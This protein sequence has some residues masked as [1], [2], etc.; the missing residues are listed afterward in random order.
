MRLRGPE[1]CLC[2]F[3]SATFD[4]T[5]GTSSIAASTDAVLGRASRNDGPVIDLIPVEL[6]LAPDLHALGEFEPP[7]FRFAMAARSSSRPVAGLGFSTSVLTTCC[8]RDMHSATGRAR[9]N[10]GN[11]IWGP[12]VFGRGEAQDI[13][14]DLIM[15]GLE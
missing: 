7:I 13:G 14:R 10:V 4:A 6:S 1:R 3:H 8:S 2:P 5:N 9:P 12:Q 11:Q 15:S